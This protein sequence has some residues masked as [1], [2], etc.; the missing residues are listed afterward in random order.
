M[1]KEYDETLAHEVSCTL[2]LD[3][4]SLH[5]FLKILVYLKHKKSK[6]IIKIEYIQIKIDHQNLKKLKY[7]YSNQQLPIRTYVHV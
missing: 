6:H 3:S 5:G 1:K 2:I 4:R 7:I